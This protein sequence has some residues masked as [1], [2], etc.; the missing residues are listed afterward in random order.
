MFGFPFGLAE[1]QKTK[2]A[3]TRSHSSVT[4]RV[5]LSSDEP[6]Y[7]HPKTGRFCVVVS[8]HRLGLRSDVAEAEDFYRCVDRIA[9]S[10]GEHT[11]TCTHKHTRTH[12]HAHTRTHTHTQAHTRTH[13]CTHRHTHKHT[14]THAH[15]HLHTR[16]HKHT[17]THA[18]THTRTH[19]HTPTH[20][21]TH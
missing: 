8:P 11:Q 12:A 19:A 17:R 5:N 20:T 13:T 21:H 3:Q 16:T 15:T 14:R 6:L 2:S 1:S 4:E 10:P 9:A 7:I 18:H